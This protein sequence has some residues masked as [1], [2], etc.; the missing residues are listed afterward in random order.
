MEIVGACETDCRWQQNDLLAINSEV[1]M[2]QTAYSFS[3]WHLS[4]S[5]IQN[6]ECFVSLIVHCFF[7]TLWKGA[8]LRTIWVSGV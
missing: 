2:E 1:P 7:A 6:I 8:H 5:K 3:F 4:T